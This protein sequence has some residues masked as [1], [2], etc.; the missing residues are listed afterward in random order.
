[1]TARLTKES[2]SKLSLL[3]MGRGDLL[4]SLKLIFTRNVSWRREE[5]FGK[6]LCS[7]ML[8]EHRCMFDIVSRDVEER[9]RVD[10]CNQ[11]S[12]FVSSFVERRGMKDVFIPTFLYLTTIEIYRV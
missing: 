12:I 11:S 7:K 8:F 6:R 5:K 1:M 3:D 9:D 2:F 10:R 4:S